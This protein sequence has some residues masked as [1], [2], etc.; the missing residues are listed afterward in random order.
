LAHLLSKPFMANMGDDD[1]ESWASGTAVLVQST[2]APL[3]LVAGALFATDMHVAR[4]LESSPRSSTNNPHN[5]FF[6]ACRGFLEK[7]RSWP[8]SV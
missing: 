2:M 5:L 4:S 3:V 6:L 1:G 8:W 7:K